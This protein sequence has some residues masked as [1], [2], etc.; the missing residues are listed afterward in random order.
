MGDVSAYSWQRIKLVGGEMRE[1]SP[2]ID[3]YKHGLDQPTCP[4]RIETNVAENN[5]GEMKINLSPSVS[6]SQDGVYISWRDKTS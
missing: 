3:W 6:I 4:V 5:E 2:F 1:F